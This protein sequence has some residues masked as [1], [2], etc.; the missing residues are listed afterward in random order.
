MPDCDAGKP[1]VPVLQ[2]GQWKLPQKEMLGLATSVRRV[3]RI[4]FF[5]H[6]TFEQVMPILM[7]E[8]NKLPTN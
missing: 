8:G 5:L 2:A 7:R 6:L 1:I 4:L 3:A